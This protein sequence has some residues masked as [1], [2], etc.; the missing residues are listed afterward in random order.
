MEYQIG[1]FNVYAVYL[2]PARSISRGFKAPEDSSV[3]VAGRIRGFSA[4][5]PFAQAQVAEGSCEGYPHPELGCAHLVLTPVKH[6]GTLQIVCAVALRNSHGSDIKPIFIQHCADLLI[7][8]T[9]GPIK[10][11]LQQYP[12]ITTVP[13]CVST[14]PS[15]FFSLIPL[16]IPGLHSRWY[17]CL[18]LHKRAEVVS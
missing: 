13:V 9:Y 18:H 8:S 10:V 4:H 3:L 6:R 11:I 15:W 5:Q 2:V 7:F 14:S 1:G 16:D 12:S 17:D